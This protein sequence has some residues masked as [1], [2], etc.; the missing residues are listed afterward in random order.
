MRIAVLGSG[1][2]GCAVAFDCA[3]HG[4]RVSLFDFDAFPDHIRGINDAGGISAEGELKEGDVIEV[5]NLKM[6]VLHTP[7]HS[8]GG[9][10]LK[11]QGMPMVV[12]GDCLFQFSIGRTDFPGASHSLLIRSI[13]EKLL[14]L[15]D[16]CEVYPGHGPPTLIG[17]ERKFNPFLQED[18]TV[19]GGSS[20]IIPP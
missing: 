7:G 9:V 14:V 5:G 20:I 3:Q 1:N 11:I 4:H 12:V 17:R 13:K 19:G 15:G 18:G 16:D 6:E 8:P 2:G 10:S